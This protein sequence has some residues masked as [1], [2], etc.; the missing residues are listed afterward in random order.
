MDTKHLARSH[1]IGTKI[2]LI[3]QKRVKTALAQ[4]GQRA[5][6]AVEEAAGDKVPDGAKEGWL[7][8]LVADAIANGQFVLVVKTQH[9]AQTVA[10]REVIQ[11]AVG[12]YKDEI[13]R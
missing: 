3:H 10:A 5:R 7:S 1:E 9:E 8:N 12:D 2:S 13:A 6:A 4:F 11:A